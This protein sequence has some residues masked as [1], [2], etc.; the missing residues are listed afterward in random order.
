MSF[1]SLS[2]KYESLG[3]E[4]L[5]FLFAFLHKLKLIDTF[6]QTTAVVAPEQRHK[7]LIFEIHAW[8]GITLIKNT[9][10]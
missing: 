4:I 2:N 3:Y 8:H 1:Q 7:P 6:Y 9:G 10:K 5:S